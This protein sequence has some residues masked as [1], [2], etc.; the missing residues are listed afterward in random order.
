MNF[1]MFL[2]NLIFFYFSN[3]I[4]LTYHS[5]IQKLYCHFYVEY[6]MSSAPISVDNMYGRTGVHTEERCSRYDKRVQ[7]QQF[8]WWDRHHQIKGGVDFWFSYVNVSC[9]VTPSHQ[10]PVALCYGVFYL[11]VRVY[12]T[13]WSYV[14][15]GFPAY[16]H[17]NPSRFPC[18][19]KNFPIL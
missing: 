10:N 9:I 15:V 13:F 3:Q 8:S 1:F 14:W 17:E 19:H 6:P 12:C 2:Q 7:W 18:V 4:L 5:F 11:W 16:R